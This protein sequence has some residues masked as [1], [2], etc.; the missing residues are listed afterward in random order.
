MRFGEFA[1]RFREVMATVAPNLTV[2]IGER[3]LPEFSAPGHVWIAPMGRCSWGRP[4]K[5]SAGQLFE[6]KRGCVVRVWGNETVPDTDRWDDAD[7]L[8]DLV[9]NALERV[10]PGRIEP[11]DLDHPAATVESYGEQDAFA[12]TLSRGVPANRRVATMP[13][14]PLE[15]MSPP[16]PLNPDG[17]LGTV[18]VTITDEMEG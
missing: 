12:F 17:N 14:L 11:T 9:L 6:I 10:A 16:N 1:Q 3:H 2:D 5:M 8:G 4:V 18:T 13:I 7:D 15:P